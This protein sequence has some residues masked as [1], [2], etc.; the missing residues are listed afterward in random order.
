[1]QSGPA[2]LP[3]L[4]LFLLIALP[5][6][7]ALR[8]P[9][10]AA[11]QRRELSTVPASYPLQVVVNGNGTI[12]S[13]PPGIHCGNDCSELLPAG[14][15]VTLTA[16]PDDDSLFSGW[17]GAC[18]GSNQ[19][20]ELTL[21]TSQVVTAAFAIRTFEVTVEV[22]GEGMVTSD[23]PGIAC[24]SDCRHTYPMGALVILTA[25]PAAGAGFVAWG[26]ACQGAAPVCSFLM[27]ETRAVLATFGLT[28]ALYL[29]LLP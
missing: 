24:G 12:I 8:T 4:M 17:S 9:E 22:A 13:T 27:N 29:P 14:A 19:T 15:S 16:A 7:L 18:S 2:R 1:M 6:A 11:R 5:S 23:P 26:G 25:Q 28:K 21:D 20:C 10:L 3:K